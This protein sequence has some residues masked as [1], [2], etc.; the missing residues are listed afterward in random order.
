[1]LFRSGETVGGEPDGPVPRRPLELAVHLDQGVG[2][3]VRAVDQVGVEAPLDAELRAV[4]GGV[5][6]G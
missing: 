1:M 6:Y 2:Q 5:I 4:D 3:P